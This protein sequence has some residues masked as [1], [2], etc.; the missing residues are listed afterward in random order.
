MASSRPG[1]TTRPAEYR[2]ERVRGVACFDIVIERRIYIELGHE[3]YEKST[4]QHRAV[5]QSS[6]DYHDQRDISRK[7]CESA[8]LQ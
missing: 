5:V 2:A 8:A 3:A 6:I 1:K 7:V 4:S